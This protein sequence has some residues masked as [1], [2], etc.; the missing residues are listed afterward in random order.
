M[1]YSHKKHQLIL[2]EDIYQLHSRNNPHYSSGRAGQGFSS[3][4]AA[5]SIAA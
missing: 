3:M 4:P 2:T 1:I 5:A